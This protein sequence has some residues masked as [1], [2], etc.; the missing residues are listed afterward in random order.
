MASL[1]LDPPSATAARVSVGAHHERVEDA[2]D[3]HDIGAAGF[4]GEVWQRRAPG[5]TRVEVALA[6]GAAG[7]VLRAQMVATEPDSSRQAPTMRPGVRESASTPEALIASRL[8]SVADEAPP[9]LGLMWRD[10]DESLDRLGMRDATRCEVG[11]AICSASGMAEQLD[12]VLEP[13]LSD[14]GDA[15]VALRVARFGSVERTRVDAGRVGEATNGVDVVAP[16][17]HG[18]AFEVAEPWRRGLGRG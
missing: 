9:G 15:R 18:A 7:F 13:R 6:R 8:V 17:G 14:R 11:A 2:F 16:A 12:R 10:T 3:D 4:V 5:T 1:A